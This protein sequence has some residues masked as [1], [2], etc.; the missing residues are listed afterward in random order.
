M[1][2]SDLRGALDQKRNYCTCS[3]MYV[4]LYMLYVKGCIRA[5]VRKPITYLCAKVY[6]KWHTKGLATVT[7]NNGES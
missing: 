1:K 5:V 4:C 2:N 3:F 6:D 7:L